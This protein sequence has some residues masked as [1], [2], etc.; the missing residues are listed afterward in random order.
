ME[1]EFWGVRGTAPAPGAAWVR[2]GGHTT[3]SSVRVGTGEYIVIDAGTGLRELGDRIMAEGE[4]GTSG[5]TSC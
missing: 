3:C 2:Y 1:L 4:T 5:S